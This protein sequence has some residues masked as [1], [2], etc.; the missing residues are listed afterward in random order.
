M[1]IDLSN[2]TIKRLFDEQIKKL[3]MKAC[4]LDS[5]D[6]QFSDRYQNFDAGCFV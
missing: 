2:E 6:Y 1:P 4:G 5:F 3:T